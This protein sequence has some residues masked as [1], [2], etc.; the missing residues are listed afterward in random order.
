MWHDLS[1]C[2]TTDS[3]VTWLIH[4]WHDWIICDMTY[5]Y[6]TRLIHMWHDLSICDTTDSYVTWL[7]QCNSGGRE[8]CFP[9]VMRTRLNNTSLCNTWNNSAVSPLCA[10]FLFLTV[11]CTSFLSQSLSRL[12]VLS[13]APSLPRSLAPSLALSVDLCTLGE[14]LHPTTTIP[15]WQRVESLPKPRVRVRQ[16]VFWVESNALMRWYLAIKRMARCSSLVSNTHE[17]ARAL[18]TCATASSACCDRPERWR[19][20]TYRIQ[21]STFW[22]M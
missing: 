16:Y 18:F 10:L 17:Q 5:P 21:P 20:S 12:L 13:L 8:E 6:V 3:Y 4:M 15:A 22:H 9:A 1:I 2:D 14:K 11:C 7:I 19:A